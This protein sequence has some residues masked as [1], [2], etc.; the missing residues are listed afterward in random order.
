VLGPVGPVGPAGAQGVAGAAGAAG[1]AGAEGV[2][3]VADP[4]RLGNL[5]TSLRDVAAEA[6]R[7]NATDF[8]VMEQ[9]LTV[10]ALL[11][12]YI[13]FELD[14][15]EKENEIDTLQES[16]DA[17]KAVK[18][19]EKCKNKP[20]TQRSAPMLLASFA[21]VLLADRAP[22]SFFLADAAWI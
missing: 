6:D 17:L 10:A 19:N 13:A 9:G 12:Q 5:L 18:I 4:S 11:E 21:C 7:V 22:P 14:L 16:I 20:S 2:Q 3:G 1:D 15:A 8:A